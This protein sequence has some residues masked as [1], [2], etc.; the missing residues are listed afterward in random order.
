[1]QPDV[2]I[3]GIALSEIVDATHTG[4]YHIG[5]WARGRNWEFRAK[6]APGEAFHIGQQLSA[7]SQAEKI[8]GL[9]LSEE[10]FPDY[11]AARDY[12]AGFED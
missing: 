11:N 2:R 5:F 3:G 8:R 4:I 9:T 6:M 1:M 12:I 7:L 10:S